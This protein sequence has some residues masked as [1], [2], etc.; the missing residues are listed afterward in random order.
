[1]ISNQQVWTACWSALVQSGWSSLRVSWYL[2]RWFMKTIPHRGAV[3]VADVLKALCHCVRAASLNSKYELPDSLPREISRAFVA[4]AKR[5]GRDGFAFSRMSRSFPLPSPKGVDRVVRD[6]MEIASQR[7]PTLAEGNR[8]MDHDLYMFVRDTCAKVRDH[9]PRTLPS[10][11]ASC[12]ELSAAKGGVNGYFTM[13]GDDYIIAVCQEYHFPGWCHDRRPRNGGD[14]VPN[15]GMLPVETILERLTKFGQ[16]SLGNFCLSVVRSHGRADL[17]PRAVSRALG[18]L[19]SIRDRAE[20]REDNLPV[21]TNPTTRAEV[22]R[23]PGYKYRLVGVPNA[24]VFAEGD[25]IRRSAPMMPKA[26]WFVK[27]GH[28]PGGKMFKVAGDFLS[29]DLSKATD[30]LSHV[31]VATVIRALH[32][33]GAIRPSDRMPA[34]WGLGLVQDTIWNHKDLQW[35]ARRGSPMGTPLSFVVLSWVSAWTVRALADGRVHGDDAVGVVTDPQFVDEYEVAVESTGASLNRLKSYMSANRFTFCETWGIR[36]RNPRTKKDNGFNVFVPPPCP[37]PG[38]KAPLVAESRTSSLYLKRQERVMRTLFPWIANDPRLNLPVEIGG[39]GYTGR[40]L[41]VSKAVRRRLAMALSKG[42]AEYA[43]ASALCG[44]KPFR[45]GGLFPRLLVQQPKEGKLWWKAVKAVAPIAFRGDDLLKVEVPLPEL[46]TWQSSMSE[47]IY[48][49]LGGS[50]R[51]VKKS[52]GR[53]DRT[54]GKVFRGGK[55][56]AIRPLSRKYGVD[57]L[58]RFVNKVKNQPVKINPIIA[59]QILGRTRLS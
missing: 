6:A 15:Q 43:A 5:D 25:W 24:L 7:A 41:A 32:D 12:F 20:A 1:M 13:R 29:S 2:H 14:G 30:G 37:P 31:C 4:L 49:A 48:Y 10:S 19:L 50:V 44:K 55:A 18:I 16:G 58:V 42:V 59:N 56:P 8:W 54:R 36:T 40:G 17:E 35:V 21:W 26:H 53:P 45:E 3:F 39:L 28:H 11:T 22:I 27:E 34:L 33:G 52:V 9:R 46:V 57:A 51:T 38:I 47:K 23:S